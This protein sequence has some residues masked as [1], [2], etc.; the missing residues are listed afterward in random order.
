LSIKFSNNLSQKLVYSDFID[1][2]S[3]DHLDIL[4]VF[5]CWHA[6]N[7]GHVCN[8]K[9]KHYHVDQMSWL[10][11]E[12]I[13]LSENVRQSKSFLFYRPLIDTLQTIWRAQISKFDVF[14]P[15]FPLNVKM[16]YNIKQTLSVLTMYDIWDLW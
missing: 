12:F 2:V 11:K 1:F 5:Q 3:D 13:Y 8:T 14:H 15:L 16:Q 4:I 9:Y 6:H 10:H 7:Y